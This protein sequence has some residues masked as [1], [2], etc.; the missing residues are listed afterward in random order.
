MK[1]SFSL[2]ALAAGALILT[3]LV[4][5]MSDD[6]K[7]PGYNT[8]TGGTTGQGGATGQGGGAGTTNQGG[9]P[10]QGGGTAG[11]GGGTTVC[12]EG[13]PTTVAA[14]AKGEFGAGLAAKFTGIAMTGP[15]LVYTNSSKGT[16]MWGVFVKDPD[17]SF[18]TMVYSYGD[19]AVL[20]GEGKMGPCPAATTSGLLDGVQKGDKLEIVGTTGSYVTKSCSADGGVTPAAQVQVEVKKTEP[21]CGMTKVGTGDANPTVTTDLAGI[22]AGKPELQGMLV[23]IE[24][25]DAEDWPDGGA[26]GPYGIIQIAGG[27]G[28]EIHDKFY[29]KDK[30]APVFCKGQHFNKITGIV[31]LDY[32]DWVIQ[33]LDPALDFDPPS[34]ATCP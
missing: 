19:N 20:D 17:A 22:V 6:E 1:R 33:P 12:M 14:V 8:G 15:V 23:T 7:D 10:G 24:N 27:S 29:Y 9:N 28:L 16:C 25:V 32:C 3:G 5:C 34:P 26:V 18:A 2:A 21:K 11:G 13:Q 30:G 4:A 31:H